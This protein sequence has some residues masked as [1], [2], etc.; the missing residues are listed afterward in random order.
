MDISTLIGFV[1]TFF[2][3]LSAMTAGGGDIGMFYDQPS[4]MMV[5]PVMKSLS[6]DMK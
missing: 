1:A 4:M 6:A 5:C 2:L 3:V